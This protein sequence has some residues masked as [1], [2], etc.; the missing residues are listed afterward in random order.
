LR[1]QNFVLNYIEAQVESV[2]VRHAQPDEYALIVPDADMAI[3]VRT[4]KERVEV[5]GSSVVFVPAG[6]SQ[7]RAQVSGRIVRLV[8]SRS[9]DMAAKCLNAQSYDEAHPYIPPFEEWPD[10][11]GEPKIRAYPLVAP[12][13]PGR[14]GS[15][16]RC[17]T[18]MIN[19]IDP[20][21]GMRDATRM[22]PHHH[23][24][25]EQCSLAV[26]GSFVHY[27]R[28]PWTTNLEHWRKDESELC[29]APSAVVIPPRAIHTSRAVGSG[30]NRLIDIF[31][32]PR[33]DF[34][35]RPG[36]VLN[37]DDYPLQEPRTENV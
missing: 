16:Y 4:S 37:D 6:Y 29:E 33:L 11:P 32:P 22:S 35:E 8:T 10:A 19:A 13:E 1:G 18:F 30:L 2:F 14:F 23:D 28:W 17:S 26:E 24:D 31:C 12:P 20:L 7:V 21:R 27:I 34:S 25:F 36:W 15:I 9:R 5:S 3:E